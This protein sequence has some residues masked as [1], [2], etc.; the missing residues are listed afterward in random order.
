MAVRTGP[1]L[2]N[3]R[4][5]Q[6]A[7]SLTAARHC[8]L[9]SGA[10]RCGC[11][12]STA[13]PGDDPQCRHS[14]C[15]GCGN[16]D[17]A[18]ARQFVRSSL[19]L[20]KVRGNSITRALAEGRRDVRPGRTQDPRRPSLLPTEGRA[21]QPLPRWPGPA[22]VRT[23]AGRDGPFEQDGPRG[24][25]LI[26]ADRSASI[27]PAARYRKVLCRQAIAMSFKARTRYSSGLAP[28]ALCRPAK[29]D[30][31]IPQPDPRLTRAGTG[32][33]P[34][35]CGRAADAP[36]DRRARGNRYSDHCYCVTREGKHL[37]E[38]KPQ[39][40]ATKALPHG[41]QCESPPA[42]RV[43]LTG[44]LLETVRPKE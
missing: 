21:R 14:T 1:R 9:F 32:R 34:R 36:A 20:L 44:C 41:S 18:D 16:V 30:I 29:R 28:S 24:A 38:R 31:R 11:N 19:D 5:R 42:L 39:I 3:V 43:L 7:G 10:R 35:R 12:R 8:R 6:R 4:F 2:V 37:H 27:Q 25:G 22:M 26:P 33:A 15:A 17:R 13:T 23:A 40:G